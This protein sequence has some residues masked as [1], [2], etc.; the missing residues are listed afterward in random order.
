MARQIG[1]IACGSIC[2]YIDDLAARG[3]RQGGHRANEPVAVAGNA[4]GSAVEDRADCIS[5]APTAAACRPAPHAVGS[6]EKLRIVQRIHQEWRRS[7]HRV[8]IAAHLSVCDDWTSTECGG[9]A[10]SRL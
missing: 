3:E 10:G 9:R 7:R 4:G 5:R 1:A 6:N 2:S 8:T